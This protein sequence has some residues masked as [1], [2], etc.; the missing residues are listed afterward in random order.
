MAW[1]L[2]LLLA[3]FPAAA[4][5]PERPFVSESTLSQRDF[6]LLTS[7]RDDKSLAGDPDLLKIAARRAEDY[8]RCGEDVACRLAALRFTPAQVEEIAGHLPEGWRHEAAA[9]NHI[10]SVYG[11]GEKPRYP[12]IDSLSYPVLP[13]DYQALLRLILDGLDL[14]SRPDMV[15]EP[16]LRFALRLLQADY[17]DEAGRFWPLEPV[18]NAAA[19]G[20]LGSIDWSAFPYSVILVPGAG[21]DV[22]GLPLSPVGAE[23]LRLAVAAWREG[24]A[25]YLLVSGGY[26]HPAQTPFCEAVEMRRYLREIYGIPADAILIEPQARHTTT[27]I[28]NA[29]R[30]VFDYGLP[31]DKPMLIV[32]DPIQIDH[33]A[34]AAFIRRN[35]DELGYQPATLGNRL[36]PV[37]LE[38]IPSRQSLYRDAAGDPL[39]P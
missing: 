20:H 33:I 6:P 30:Q 2:F 32:S 27:N 17:R 18:E 21:P 5:P 31:G 37:R 13:K 4:T 24:S 25:P 28:R 16:S 34:D 14:P 22:T 12:D 1:L 9:I 11:E 15:F 3:A 36:S 7:L 35:Q 8:R 23:R 10:I 19:L 26:V 39:D 29:A 38:A